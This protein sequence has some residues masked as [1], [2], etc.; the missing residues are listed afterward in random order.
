MKALKR[1]SSTGS[2]N[3]GTN[4]SAQGGKW[5]GR[6][7]YVVAVLPFVPIALQKLHHE[8]AAKQGAA[9]AA[10]AK[11]ADV[12]ICDENAKEPALLKQLSVKILPVEKMVNFEW[13]TRMLKS[14]TFVETSSYM[15]SSE[16]TVS[17]PIADVRTIEKAL[18][19]WI[20][21]SFPPRYKQNS[22]TLVRLCFGDCGVDA[23]R[24]EIN[25]LDRPDKSL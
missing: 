21:D 6:S 15:W 22:I 13:L 18:K 10:S 11:D 3:K 9:I 4:V 19:M 23:K 16:N 12:L 24:L 1:C 8:R 20:P 7:I 17:E 25:T 14:S 5:A 2:E